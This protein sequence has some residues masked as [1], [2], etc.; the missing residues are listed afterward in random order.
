MNRGN[1]EKARINQAAK[2]E[3]YVVL[4]GDRK[5]SLA[6][7]KEIET[8]LD[9]EAWSKA[10]KLI[11]CELKKKPHSHWLLTRLSTTYYEEHKYSKALVI[12]K[13]AVKLAPKCPLVLWDHACMLDM[14]GK[15]KKAIMIW[16]KLLR[17]GVNRIA[18][19]ECGEGIRW[20]RSMLNDCRYS[21]GVSYRKMGN[22][23][24][25][26]KFI[27]DHITNRAP[28]IPSIFTLS[29]VKNEL[30]NINSERIKNRPNKPSYG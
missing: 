21:I 26:I 22:I 20:S 2:R 12:S 29:L 7:G 5:M 13:K 11:L 3:M 23:S 30:T 8:Y 6:V 15:H 4:I 25:A 18:Y 9:R 10:R 27:K 19:D 17:R 1:H 24:L 14:V 28:G 16:K